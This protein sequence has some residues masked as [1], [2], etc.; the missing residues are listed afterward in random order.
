MSDRIYS[1]DDIV[2]DINDGNKDEAVAHLNHDYL[3]MS[4]TQFKSLVEEMEQKTKADDTWL[5][6]GGNN[7]YHETD[8]DGNITSVY[9]DDGYLWDTKMFN[10]QDYKGNILD[11]FGAIKRGITGAT[12]LGKD[13]K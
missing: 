1:A 3:H 10:A 8:K 6:S 13:K 5:S 4:A 9:I 2:K 12:D 7:V 11:P